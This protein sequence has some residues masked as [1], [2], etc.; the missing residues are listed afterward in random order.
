MSEIGP[1]WY[2]EHHAAGGDGDVHEGDGD[3]QDEEEGGGSVA[4]AH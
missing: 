1:I 4:D 3:V 2:S